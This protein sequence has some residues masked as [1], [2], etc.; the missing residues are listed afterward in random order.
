VTENKG[1]KTP[2]VDG[3]RWETPEQKATAVDR[4]GQWQGYQPLPLKRIYIPKPNG[5][6]R[7]LSIPAMEDRARQALYLQALQPMAETQADPNSYGFRP[8]RRCA[9][10][11]DQCFKVLRLKTSASWILEGD[12]QSFFDHI[13]FAWIEDHIPMNKGLLAK[14]LRCGFLD[15]GTR[16]PTTAGVPHGGLIS[17]VISNLVLDGLEAVVQGSSW[18][19]RVHNINYVRWADDFIVTATSRQE[20]AEVVLPR[21][22]AFLADRGVRLSAEKTVITPLAHGFD[23]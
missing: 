14:W 21:I 17:P 10:A 1:K 15:H 16:D 20:L 3:A 11:I 5:K 22:E 18:H 6:H 23:F 12:T 13:A 7:P 19:R 8:K 2:G 4:I 9:D